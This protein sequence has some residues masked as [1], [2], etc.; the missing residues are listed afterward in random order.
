MKVWKRFEEVPR[1]YL[2]SF[3]RNVAAAPDFSNNTLPNGAL[4]FQSG[5][6][7]FKLRYR[8]A[9]MSNVCCGIMAVYS[10]LTLAGIAVDFLK[11]SAEFE[12]ASVPAIPPGVFGSN[13]FLIDRCLSSYGVSFKKYR[14]LNELENALTTG[15]LGIVSYMFGRLDPRGHTFAVERT[16]D[17]IVTYNRFSNDRE[18]GSALSVRD[19]LKR[20]NIFLTGYVV[21]KR[22]TE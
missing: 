5:G 10:V 19:V 12:Q 18:T 14:R 3:E 22:E 13:P 9:K 8:C 15:K 4:I 21:E 11:L 20:K 2:R 17:G 16:S 7:F 1:R 6:A